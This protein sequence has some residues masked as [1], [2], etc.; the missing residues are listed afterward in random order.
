MHVLCSQHDPAAEIG[1]DPTESSF[2]KAMQ[3]AVGTLSII[4]GEAYAYSRIWCLLLSAQP[5]LST[6]LDPGAASRCP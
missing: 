4:D 3:L 6:P 2:F 1:Q 5:S